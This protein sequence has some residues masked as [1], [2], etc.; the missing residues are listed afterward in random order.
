[1]LEYSLRNSTIFT[2]R[3]HCSKEQV[4][5][6]FT[7]QMQARLLEE[8]HHPIKRNTFCRVATK[9]LRHDYSMTLSPV[10]I[11]NP[12]ICRPA[13]C[14]WGQAFSKC[15]ANGPVVLLE[16]S[17]T[18]YNTS[19]ALILYY[20]I[21]QKWNTT[22]QTLS[23]S[24]WLLLR[25]LV[26]HVFVMGKRVGQLLMNELDL[27]LSVCIIQGQRPP[28]QF[29]QFAPSLKDPCHLRLMT[30]LRQRQY[31]W[32]FLGIPEII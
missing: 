6:I 25:S 21:V 12:L 18:T 24:H 16:Q 28:T 17:A 7:I 19:D 31:T 23:S 8:A 9:W 22:K 14:L 20:T 29:N 11:Q 30:R 26:L 32:A 15:C 4:S 13:V 3:C 5:T 2:V 1:M 10:A 27:W